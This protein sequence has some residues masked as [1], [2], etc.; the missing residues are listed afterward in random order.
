MSDVVSAQYQQVPLRLKQFRHKLGLN[1]EDFGKL[2]E[3]GQGGVS[4]MEKGTSVLTLLTIYKLLGQGLNPDW[5]LLGKGPMLYADR[6][7]KDA[8]VLETRKF[9]Q[10]TEYVVRVPT[11]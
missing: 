1:Q 7:D 9:G 6:E 5:L 2:L 3:L 8:P 10:Y 4:A 11:V